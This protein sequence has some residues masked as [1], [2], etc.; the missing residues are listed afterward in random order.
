M[1]GTLGKEFKNQNSKIPL[2][3]TAGFRDCVKTRK[4]DFKTAKKWSSNP[5]A[6]KKTR[7]IEFVEVGFL[8]LEPASEFSHSLFSP[9]Q[10]PKLIRLHLT[11]RCETF[12][13]SIRLFKVQQGR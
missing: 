7:H 4:D 8:A 12:Q 5:S 6:R 2:T 9:Q 10:V 11:L 3:R 13:L 1:V